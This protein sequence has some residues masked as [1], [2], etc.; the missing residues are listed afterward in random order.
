MLYPKPNGEPAALTSESNLDSLLS[1]AYALRDRLEEIS[2]SVAFA[3]D[4]HSEI[5]IALPTEGLLSSRYSGSRQH[6]VHD[7]ALPHRGIDLAA[8]M[9]TPVFAP[10]AGRVV[11]ISRTAGY[12]LMLEID[13]GAGV[14]TRYAHL[15]RTLVRRGERILKGTPIAAVGSSGLSTGPH[16]HYEIL[17]HGSAVDPMVF[18][19]HV[20]N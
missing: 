15:S 4:Q 7:R 17:V 5:P 13:H 19:G 14:V 3:V 16:L 11:G 20:A 6:P 18:I 8:P 10:A 12:G 2:D 9:G 1:Q